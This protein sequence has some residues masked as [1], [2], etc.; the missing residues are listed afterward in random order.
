M[1]ALYAFDQ[2]QLPHLQANQLVS[3][4]ARQEAEAF[5]AI[6]ADEDSE[7]VD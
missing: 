3:R 7:S 6:E 4:M 2:E 1:R 5:E